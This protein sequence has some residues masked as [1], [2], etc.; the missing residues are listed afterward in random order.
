VGAQAALDLLY[1]GRRVKGEEALALGLSDRLAAAG[2]ER[3]QARALAAEVAASAPLAVRAIRAT[4]RGGLADAVRAATEREGQ[5]QA[6]LLAS[7]DFREGVR[8]TAERRTS[9]FSGR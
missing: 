4:L 1:T 6:R 3:A 7:E 9:R 5:E 2:E 8:A